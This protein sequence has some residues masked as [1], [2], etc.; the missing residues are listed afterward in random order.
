M[1]KNT[2]LNMSRTFGIEIEFGGVARDTVMSA[3]R[4]AG[5]RAEQQ[6]WMRHEDRDYSNY[7]WQMTTDGSVRVNGF[8]NELVSPPMSIEGG[9]L[10]EITRVCAILEQCGAEVNKTCGLHV[11]HDAHEFDIKSFKNLFALYTRY[12]EAIDELMPKS[13]RGDDSHYAQSMIKT[14]LETTLERL[15]DCKNVEQIAGM[16][17]SRYQ[18]LNIHSFMHH[19]TV[20]FRQHNGTT[21]AD[22]I[23]NWVLITQAMVNRATG[24]TVQASGVAGDWFNFKKAIRAYKWM[25]ASEELVGAVDYMNKRRRKLA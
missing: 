24:A 3:M 19:G 8:G 17:P 20:E 2:G 6:G 11:H 5:I 1:K 22:K 16:Y 10:E 23:I 9:G 4:A 25:G 21:N 14:R 13:R 12:E 18:K 15:A 7:I